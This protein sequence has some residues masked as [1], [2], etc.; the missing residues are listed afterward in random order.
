MKKMLCVLSC[1]AICIMSI[2]N[3]KATNVISLNK[4]VEFVRTNER[5]GITSYQDLA[6]LKG[7]LDF[8]EKIN[9]AATEIEKKSYLSSIINTKEFSNQKYNKG[10]IYLP[11]YSNLNKKEKA[12]AKENPVV[13]VAAYAWADEATTRTVKMYG[14]NGFQDNSDA[15]RHGCWNILMTG[16]MGYYWAERW[17]SAHEYG[18]SGVDTT[19]DLRNNKIGRDSWVKGKSDS[20]LAGII[21]SKVNTG[22]M[23]RISGGILIRTSGGRISSYS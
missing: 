11:G 12:L 21:A 8:F 9:P 4:E 6:Y 16:H 3:V 23:W 1:S 18:A 13:A 2:Q 5:E 15:F 19:M 20:Q 10:S 22:K 17:A 14:K 7:K